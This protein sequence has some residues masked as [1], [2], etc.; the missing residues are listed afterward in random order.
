AYHNI[1]DSKKGWFRVREKDG[2]WKAWPDS[3]RLTQWYGCMETNPLQ[4]GWFVPQD[5]TGMVKMMGGNKKVIAD[6]NWM[7]DKTPDN[8]M[9]NDF[10]NHANEPVH[11]VPFLFNRI[12]A[13]W[14]TQKWTREITRRAYKNSVEGLVGNEDVGQMS[15]WY[16]LAAAG[17]HPICPGDTRQ[18]ITSPSF[19]K[20]VFKLDKAYAKGGTFTIAA[21]NNSAK[22]VYIQ[23][24]RLNGRPY[25]KCYI[26]YSEIAA[27]GYLEL[28]MGPIPS[29][30]WGS[31]K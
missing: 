1:W 31:T 12:G 2:S 22:N 15:A 16:I 5:V 10:Y 20:T 25:K 17:I 18:E 19:D 11:Q 30:T 3:G 4:Q 7:F 13:P 14:Y 8:M 23:S 27:G 29:K 6:L 24:A 26:D 28:T 21:K 9:W